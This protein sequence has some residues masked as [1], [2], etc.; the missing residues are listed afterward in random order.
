MTVGKFEVIESGDDDVPK[1]PARCAI[2]NYIA[3]QIPWARH[4]TVGMETIRLYDYRCV[5]NP[6]GLVGKCARCPARCLVW[7]TPLRVRQAIKEFDAI[8]HAVFPAFTLRFEEAQ[9]VPATQDRVRKRQSMDAYRQAIADGEHKPVRRTAKAKAR[10]MS[11]R[12]H[13]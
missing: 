2:K 6:E 1:D 11:V 9:L 13:G 10:A 3:R 7:A 8:H 5:H 12:R 4:I